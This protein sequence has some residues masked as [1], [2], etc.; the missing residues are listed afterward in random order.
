MKITYE[1]IKE[2]SGEPVTKADLYN[3]YL[4]LQSLYE[5]D[6]LPEKVIQINQER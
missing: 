4:K 1:P 6:S 2:D 5:A 3:L